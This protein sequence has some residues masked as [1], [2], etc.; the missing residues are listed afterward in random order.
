M[1]GLAQARAPQVRV[2]W[3]GRIW[4]SHLVFATLLVAGVALRLATTVAYSPAFIYG[5][6]RFYL[7][8][9][10]GAWIP[11]TARTTAYSILL[12]GLLPFGGLDAVVAVQHL[13]GLATAAVLYIFLLRWGCRR[14]WAALATL[15]VLLD[16]LQVVLEHYILTDVPAEAIIVAGL[17]VLAWPT[18]PRPPDPLGP[19]PA[20]RAVITPVRAATGG[21]LLGLATVTRSG[22]LAVGVVGVG[23]VLLAAR[24]GWR[25]R[26]SV[27]LLTAVMF[28]A[29]IAA[30]AGWMK[31]ARGS[32]GLTYHYAGH[33]LYGRVAAFEDCTGLDL[34]P[35]EQELCSPLPPSQ[36]NP[37]RLLW[38]GSSPSWAIT[39]PP[40][41][42]V[43]EVDGDFARRVIRHQPLDYLRIVSA[44]LLYDFSPTRG[45]GPE[46]NA[47][48]HF[49]YWPFY[50]DWVDDMQ[51]VVTKYGGSDIHVDTAL[52]TPLTAYGRWY[53]P[54]VLLGA[55]MLAGLAAAAGAAR[56]RHSG[57]RL[58]CLLFSAGLMA[59]LIAPAMLDGYTVRYIIPELVL[60]PAAGVL[61]LTAMLAGRRDPTEP[62]SSAAAR[63][64]P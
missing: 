61:G 51:R 30:Y 54:G 58:V 29:P 31:A 45:L 2:A 3:P 8:Y 33:F 57:M 55:L 20:R 11:G 50:P 41:M 14:G 10:R 1:T 52:A 47:N 37:A 12:R 25:R 64:S 46:R 23:Y 18:N 15:P 60:A 5:D 24:P 34:P 21:L 32:F 9:T 28:A 53:T 26:I 4:R 63:R 16:P 19:R 13:L 44:D 6:S 48:W 27:T 22:D 36:R 59:T 17:V 40:G 7:G 62:G 35:P 42:T 38:R 56:A 39:P 43:D 49:R